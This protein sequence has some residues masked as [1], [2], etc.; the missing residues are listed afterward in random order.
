MQR[1]LKSVFRSSSRKHDEDSEP[2]SPQSSHTPQSSQSYANSRGA[3]LEERRDRRS[4]DSYTPTGASHQQQQSRSRPLSAAYDDRVRNVSGPA[5]SSTAGSH[6]YPRSSEPANESI[7][8][9]YQAYLP[10]LSPV[11]DSNDQ[12]PMKLE[13]DPQHMGRE[14]N[15]HHEGGVADRNIGQH[16]KSLDVSKRKPLPAPPGECHPDATV[17][18]E[19]VTAILMRNYINGFA[20]VDRDRT[21][22]DR[23]V[24]RT[25]PHTEAAPHERSQWKTTD[26]P[27]RSARNESNLGSST[28]RPQGSESDDGALRSP[29]GNLRQVESTHN[30]HNGN[31]VP[32]DRNHDIK[33]Q[34]DQLLEGVVDLRNTVDTD[35]DV[36]FAPGTLASAA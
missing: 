26:L 6:A 32:L 15:G 29:P 34:I 9:N 11:Y 4:L 30:G 25:R 18:H 35:Q 16:R 33:Q 14:S 17:L 31:V 2:G 23:L 13:D 28:R 5:A 3:S 19:A 24:H 22:N 36:T 12:P 7:A 27:E 8:T 20:V 1:K 21:T 10:A